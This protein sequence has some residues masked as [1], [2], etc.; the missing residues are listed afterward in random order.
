MG[1][2]I[3]TCSQSSSPKNILQWRN[4]TTPSPNGQNNQNEHHQEGTA[5]LCINTLRTENRPC[6]IPARPLWPESNYKDIRQT[7][8][9]ETSVKSLACNLLE[10]QHLKDKE[11]L[12]H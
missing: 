4:W 9:Q 2:M 10:C 3:F 1:G 8:T 11:R 12:R 7:Q 5:H 6:G